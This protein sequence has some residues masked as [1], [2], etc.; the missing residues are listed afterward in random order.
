MRIFFF[1]FSQKKK[2]DEIKNWWEQQNLERKKKWEQLFHNQKEFRKK[3]SL[4]GS[5]LLKLLNLPVRPNLHYICN[6]IDRIPSIKLKTQL[7]EKLSTLP[8]EF[9]KNKLLETTPTIQDN[10]D[11]FFIINKSELLKNHIEGLDLD[12]KILILYVV[13]SHETPIPSE[14][15]VKEILL[16]ID[17]QFFTKFPF[18]IYLL[19][20]VNC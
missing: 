10:L 12:K 6:D 19:P 8:I 2:M 16:E 11:E 15:Q 7:W 18:D 1:R 5:H 4:S 14:E 13:D 3:Y 17:P 9:D 20:I